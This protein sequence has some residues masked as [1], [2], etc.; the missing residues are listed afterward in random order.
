VITNALIPSSREHPL[1][2]KCWGAWTA[3]L[4]I[5]LLLPHALIAEPQA[6]DAVSQQTGT[7]EPRRLGTVS[8][9]GQL[10]VPPSRR[11]GTFAV[12]LGLSPN[13]EPK[14]VQ[15]DYLM[16][17]IL[18]RVGSK[19]TEL[20]SERRCHLVL[21]ADYYPYVRGF[22]SKSNSSDSSDE[23]RRACTGIFKTALDEI[24]NDKS[25]LIREATID[26]GSDL[27][28][29]RQTGR[30]VARKFPV[31]AATRSLH[32]AVYQIYDQASLAHVLLSLDPDEVSNISA[33]DFLGWFRGLRDRGAVRL[34]SEDS[35]MW[36]LIGITSEDQMPLLPEISMSKSA[37]HVLS[38][39][40]PDTSA[41]RAAVLIALDPPITGKVRDQALAKY[42]TGLSKEM[43]QKTDGNKA[44]THCWFEDFFG[45]E[46]W[47]AIY[48][49]A[50]DGSD[51]VL[52]QRAAEIATDS[53][54]AD[55]AARRN[56]GPQRGRPYVV[57]FGASTGD[58]APP[59][60][61]P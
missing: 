56:D 36:P 35:Q 25:E 9:F 6:A 10:V 59:T 60:A 22:L 4:V 41:I 19:L 58:P 17:R 21:S 26:L 46:T 53:A 27:V 49:D 29:S 47:A 23:A 54:I 31:L 1:S 5:A 18:G 20:K 50:D 52:R 44:R 2:V 11:L 32:E 8:S 33:S 61:G 43:D 12:D 55:L 14:T 3:T 37:K 16:A 24:S 34:I 13:A 28:R 7:A 38:I 45:R 40:D 15:R 39:R 42:C 48:F 30:D 57:I 51:P